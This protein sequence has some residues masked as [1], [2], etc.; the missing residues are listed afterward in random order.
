M[1]DLGLVIDKCNVIYAVYSCDSFTTGFFKHAWCGLVGIKETDLEYSMRDTGQE[2]EIYPNPS[3]GLLKIK[4]T[5]KN[6]GDAEIIIYDVIGVRK[7][8]T[9]LQN[10]LSGTYQKRIDLGDIP[11]GI[12]FLV[13]KQNN[14]KVYKKFLLIR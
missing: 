3:S 13:L 5:L 10:C 12:Y 9:M 1:C 4:Y 6:E 7:K 2:L 11:S 14:E 8:S